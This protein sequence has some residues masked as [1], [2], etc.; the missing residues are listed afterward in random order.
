MKCKILICACISFLRGQK[1]RS[2]YDT[3]IIDYHTK[4]YTLITDAHRTPNP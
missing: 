3:V 2:K 1:Y 4:V